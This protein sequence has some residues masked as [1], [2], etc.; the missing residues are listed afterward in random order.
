M[1]PHLSI[2][3]P[4]RDIHTSNE[5][6]C[7]DVQ[8]F[9]LSHYSFQI[10]ISSSMSEIGGKELSLTPE[11]AGTCRWEVIEEVSSPCP[12]PLAN[13]WVTAPVHVTTMD[14]SGNN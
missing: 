3:A 11:P 4:T 2:S 8:R 1:I 13:K 14:F 6:Y 10:S 5:K 12:S 7:R 9:S